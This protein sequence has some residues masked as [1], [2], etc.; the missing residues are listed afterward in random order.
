MAEG[1]STA[2]GTTIDLGNIDQEFTAA[3]AAPPAD[4]PEAPAPPDVAPFDPEAPFGR[5]IDGTP[6]T[7]PGGRPPKERPRVTTQKALDGPEKPGKDG[8]G[9][10]YAEGLKE[11]LAGVALGLAVIPMPEESALR[12]RCRVQAVVLKETGDGLAKGLAVTAEHNGIVRWGVEKLTAGGSAWVFPAALAVMP[13]AIQ[14][15]MLWKAPVEGDM[16]E[17]ADRVQEQAMAEFKAE[18]GIKDEEPQQQAA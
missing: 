7:R 13:F 3:M 1:L 12:V 11:F 18:M 6:K 10:G 16:R 17:M 14:T 8:P 9:P 15:S 4:E 2:D 5:K